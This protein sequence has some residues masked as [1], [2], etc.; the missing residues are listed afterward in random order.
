MAHFYGNLKGSRG[1]ATRCG[2]ARSGLTVSARSWKGSVTVEMTEDED[3]G[4]PCVIIRAADGSSTSGRALY[5]GPLSALVS[6]ASLVPTYSKLF[7]EV[8]K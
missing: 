6:A 3:F 4:E 5:C 2:T 7:P 1:A 8:A